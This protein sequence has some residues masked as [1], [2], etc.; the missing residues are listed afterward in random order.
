MP[1]RFNE[2]A[3]GNPTLRDSIRRTLSEKQIGCIRYLH[4]DV[5]NGVHCFTRWRKIH[6]SGCLDRWFEDEKLFLGPGAS[7]DLV[8]ERNINHDTGFQKARSRGIQHCLGRG[9]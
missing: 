8:D 6:W 1:F 3:G 5:E 9:H 7:D 2:F 4:L